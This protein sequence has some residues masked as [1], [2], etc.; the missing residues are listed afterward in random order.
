MHILMILAFLFAAAAPLAA[1][2]AEAPVVADA[3]TFMA[4]YAA[5]LRGDRAGIAARY[6]RN[7]AFFLG[8][9]RKSFE[10]HDAITAQYA[11]AQWQPPYHFEWRDLSYEPAGPDAVIIA[12]QFLWTPRESAL[13]YT[14]SHTALLHRQ[15]EVLRIRWRT[16]PRCRPAPR[17]SRTSPGRPGGSGRDR[18][19]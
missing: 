12:G 5:A 15:D 13:P 19:R 1:Q 2:R 16:N 11:G 4:D 14:Y 18:R 17:A 3:H 9:G 6:D 8:N 10:S 7:G